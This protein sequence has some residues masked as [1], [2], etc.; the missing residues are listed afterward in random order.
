[1]KKIFHQ[2]FA[3]LLVLSAMFALNSCD[4]GS[5]QKNDHTHSFT[6]Q[7]RDPKY[8]KDTGSCTEA[9]VFYYSCECGERGEQTF[10]IDSTVDHIYSKS[11]VVPTCTSE[12]YTLYTCV[13]CGLSYK[14]DDIPPT[15]EHSFESTIIP[16]TCKKYGYTSH[17][18]SVCG[19]SY[20]DSYTEPYIHQHVRMTVGR[21]I[22]VKRVNTITLMK[23][24]VLSP[25]VTII[26]K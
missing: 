26:S 5:N 25:P 10:T 18:C 13:N 3:I 17:K 22:Y 12:G 23:A 14:E 19:Y 7:N 20:N 4:N 21:Y 15:G 16:A 24:R 8:I 11:S 1:M 9:A 6:E 2:L